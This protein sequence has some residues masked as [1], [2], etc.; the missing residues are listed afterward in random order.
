MVLSQVHQGWGVRTDF[1]TVTDEP[2]LKASRVNTAMGIDTDNKA[3]RICGRDP[4]S[5]RPRLIKNNLQPFLR[6]SLLTDE[7]SAHS[8]HSRCDDYLDNSLCDSTGCSLQR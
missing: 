1:L 8:E 6:N 5:S 3:D 7:P 2:M 4:L